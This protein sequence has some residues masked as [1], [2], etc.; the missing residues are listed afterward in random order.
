MPADRS[1]PP[2]QV[3]LTPP[4]STHIRQILKEYIATQAA[5]WLFLG[6]RP[7]DVFTLEHDLEPYLRKVE[8]SDSLQEIAQRYRHPFIDYIGE[9]TRDHCGI[10]WFLTSLS[11]KNPFASP[12]YFSFCAMV[13]CMEYLATARGTMIVVCGSP[14]I[15]DALAIN[16]RG[17]GF[18]VVSCPE[19]TLCS[20]ADAITIRVLGSAQRCWFITRFGLRILLARLF[21]PTVPKLEEGET[22]VPTILIHAW[23]DQRSFLESGAFWDIFYG[24]LVPI[25]SRDAKVWYVI[26]V[27]PTMAYLLA[28][29][30][31]RG[32]KK[33]GYLLQER[34]LS[35]RDIPLALAASRRGSRELGRVPPFGNME[36]AP[37]VFD[38]QKV[39][40]LNARGA[41]SY[42]YYRAGQ[43]LAAFHPAP[44]Y[45]YTF[46]NHMWEKC[47]IKGIRE[48]GPQARVVGYAHTLVYPMNLSYSLSRHE[49]ACTPLPDLI[50]TNGTQ[51]RDV[52]IE[53][54]FPESSIHVCGALRYGALSQSRGVLKEK[55]GYA[56]LVAGS[57]SMQRTIELI[58]K[59]LQAF[60]ESPD[61]PVWIKC[62]PNLPFSFME[63]MLPPLPPHFAIREETVET[64]FSAT[65]VVL[66]TE[67]TLAVEAAACGIPVIHVKLECSLDMN[68]FEGFPTIPSLGSPGEIRHAALMLRGQSLGEIPE[69]RKFIGTLFGEVDP[70]RIRTLVH[71]HHPPVPG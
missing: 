20:L 26:D 34:F 23:A 54:G 2:V 42:L 27:L 10:S 7:E 50:L 45:L 36:I 46:E 60:A 8:I 64:L 24:D 59:A 15:Q 48:A 70:D 9:L 33:T 53:A 52:L 39:D 51:P 65:G 66:F 71:P 49:T 1:I 40:V 14:G 28:L 6:D 22:P 31:L 4:D 30:S 62:H 47:T 25:L 13:A 5:E 29:F 43:R 17:K 68:I 12:F 11:E 37:L 57:V 61:V 32:L 18:T 16:L 58:H 41:Q 69:I 67:S 55:G 3:I 63:R 35:L 19:S 21:Q 38:E 44:V 56:I